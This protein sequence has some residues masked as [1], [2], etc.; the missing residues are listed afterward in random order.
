M[1]EITLPPSLAV[2]PNIPLERQSL[3]ELRLERAYW[4]AKVESATCWGA[5]LKAAVYFRSACDV[6]IGR[7]ERDAAHG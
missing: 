2:T 6:W 4:Q 5:S 7:R 1:A 3:A